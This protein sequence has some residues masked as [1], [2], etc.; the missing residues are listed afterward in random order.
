[1]GAGRISSGACLITC[2]EAALVNR[3]GDFFRFA[4]IV[5]SLVS[6]KTDAFCR[7]ASVAPSATGAFT[8]PVAG[9]RGS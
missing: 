6:A 5:V 9:W 8:S 7:D 3:F 4:G 2:S 1:M